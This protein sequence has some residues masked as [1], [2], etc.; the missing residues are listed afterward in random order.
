MTSLQYFRYAAYALIAIGLI[1]LR[2]QPGRENLALATLF[3][4]GSGALIMA[5]TY[6]QAGK[7]FL[8]TN[9]GRVLTSLLAVGAGVF[10]ILN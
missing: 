7:K 6:L 5:L 8:A 1:N 9:A 4:V 10:A 3:I 2:Y